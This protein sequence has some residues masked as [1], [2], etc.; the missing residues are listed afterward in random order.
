MARQLGITERTVKAH[1]T[2]LMRKLGI[3]SRLEA[4]LISNLHGAEMLHKGDHP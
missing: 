4:A 1:L 3:E 2:N